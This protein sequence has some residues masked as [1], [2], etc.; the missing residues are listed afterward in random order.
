MKGEV[1]QQHQVRTQWQH[2]VTSYPRSE[3]CDS[4]D[5]L[6]VIRDN[7]TSE[8]HC[9]EIEM[10]THETWSRP[11][12]D[13]PLEAEL[14][15]HQGIKNHN[16]RALLDQSKDSSG[17]QHPVL[18]VANWISLAGSLVLLLPHQKVLP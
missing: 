15:V 14:M 13:S 7:R 18:T 4:L 11:F 8:N 6:D 2:C 12:F 16:I 10:A 5:N 17:I 1:V 3:S 9:M